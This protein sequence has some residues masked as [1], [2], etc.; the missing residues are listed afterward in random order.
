MTIG[1]EGDQGTFKSCADF[2]GQRGVKIC[3]DTPA[4]EEPARSS[5]YP[6]N[7]ANEQTHRSDST[8]NP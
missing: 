1:P 2:L 8:T 7:N 6:H 4:A 5:G 3:Q